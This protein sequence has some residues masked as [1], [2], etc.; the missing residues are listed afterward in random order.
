MKIGVPTETK[1][2]EY[3][4]ALIPDAVA[5][6]TEAGHAV[7]VQSGAGNHAGFDDEEYRAAGALIEP[8]AVKIYRDAD[9]IVKVKEPQPQE[10][11]LFRPG[12]LLF[13][14]LHLA[15]N[16]P[17]TENLIKS[18]AIAFA[19]ETVTDDNG[20]FPLLTPMSAIA[21]RVAVQA[22]AWFLQSNNGGKGV[23]LSGITGV[24]NG[25]VV[26]VGGGV[27]G[28]N[29]AQIALGLGAKVYVL[30]AN[31]KRVKQLESEYEGAINCCL[32]TPENL[33]DLLPRADI[34]VGAVLR[35]GDKAPHVLSKDDLNRMQ[36]G[37]VLVDVSIDQGGCFETSRPTTHETPTFEINGV[38]HY[39]V[40]NMPSVCAKTASQALC[41]ATLPF[42]QELADKGWQ[43]AVSSNAHLAD[44]LNVC[45]GALNLEAVAQL[46]E[47]PYAGWQTCLPGSRNDGFASLL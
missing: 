35:P 31:P 43:A 8:D 34:L 30:D 10:Y 45:Q 22:G 44:G 26:I 40:A 14:Y 33:H 32:M 16:K 25:T 20:R 21:G 47:L 46:F 2:R 29:A 18:G 6:L 24:E 15:A 28:E 41:H 36:K 23:L 12:Q 19:Y 37:S 5:R 11:A 42:I 1:I 3:R 9:M 4:V 13:T 7:F 38:Q 39:C 27:V 17:L